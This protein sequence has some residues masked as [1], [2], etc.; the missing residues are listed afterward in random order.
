MSNSRAGANAGSKL[1]RRPRKRFGQHFL[2][3]PAVVERIFGALRCQ[4]T[5]HVLEIGPGT[6]LLTERL[7]QEAGT[8]TAIEVDRDLA[9]SLQARLPALNVVQADVL[10]TDLAPYLGPEGASRIVGNL[11]YNVATPLLGH[12]FE[13]IDRIAD[14]HVMLQAEVADRLAADPGTKSYGRLSVI[15]QYYCRIERLFDVEA[16]SFTPAPKVRSTFLR[17]CARERE[18]CDVGNLAAVLRAAFGQRRKTLGNALKSFAPDWHALGLDPGARAENLRV[19]DFI[20]I[21]NAPASRASGDFA[22]RNLGE[23]KADRHGQPSADSGA[24]DNEG[25][26]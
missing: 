13:V 10:T 24:E 12:L 11:P 8:V 6:G 19:A 14:V 7:C 3:D 17:L 9:A 1:P 20:A 26:P 16:A 21:A 2:T 23:P 15:S 4:A 18:P 25:D 5:D 22:K